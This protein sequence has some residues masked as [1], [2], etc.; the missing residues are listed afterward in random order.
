MVRYTFYFRRHEGPFSRISEL[1]ISSNLSVWSMSIFLLKNNEILR[2]DYKL[3]INRLQINICIA[4]NHFT[5]WKKIIIIKER[6]IPYHQILAALYYFFDSLL[7]SI[8]SLLCRLNPSAIV[9]CF[10]FFS[11][12]FLTHVPTNCQENCWKIIWPIDCCRIHL[13]RMPAILFTNISVGAV[14]KNVFIYYRIQGGGVMIMS[15]TFFFF[16]FFLFG[17]IPQVLFMSLWA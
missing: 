5:I 16:I 9:D 15:L 17:H 1:D 13:A 6:L 3:K 12:W 4:R 11:R 14:F 2:N 10:Q 8:F 7:V